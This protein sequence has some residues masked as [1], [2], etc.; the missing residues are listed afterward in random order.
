MHVIFTEEDYK[1]YPFLPEA[2][3]LIEKAGLTLDDI[4]EG[5]IGLKIL[6]S[7]KKRV[8]DVIVNREY[9]DPID[10]ADLEVAYFVSSLII[11]SEIG[12]NFL[13]ERYATVFSKKI[14]GFFEQELRRGES[15]DTSITKLIYI[16]R[17]ISSWN[18]SLRNGELKI[19][20]KD[21]VNLAPEYR[22]SWKLVNRVLDKGFLTI[23]PAEL[24]RLL[25]TGVKKYVLS[26]I[27]NIKV[28][29]DQLPE[30]FYMVI[31]EASRTW[32]QIKSNFA[33]I[34]G[35]IEAEKVPGLFPPCIQSLIDSL[36]AGKNLPHSA[37]FA[38]AAFLLNI[39][40]SIDEVLEV[41]SFSPDFREDL[42]RYQVEH[43]AGLRGSRTKYSPYKCDNMRSLGLCR[44]RC[45]GIRHPLQFFFR[46]V[47]GRKPEVKEIG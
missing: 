6:E 19:F 22:G 42:A 47:R 9:P 18:V 34:R 29:Y 28:N 21:F 30:S 35:K 15:I 38:L 46:A 43:I 12:D 20:F 16:G 4:G 23:S 5:E 11:I 13:A 8:L 3:R 41:F 37:R 17:Q 36:K 7:A 25:E 14:G 45:R 40:Y 44:W 24:A 1:K 33:T 32:S 26:L 39:G 31:E 2:I 27:E 10:D